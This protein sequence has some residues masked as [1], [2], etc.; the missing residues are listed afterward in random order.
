MPI[1]SVTTPGAL[2]FSTGASAAA[3]A[4]AQDAV[5]KQG[6]TQAEKEAA[7]LHDVNQGQKLDKEPVT[8]DNHGKLGKDDFM[9]LMIATL[10]YQDPSNPMDTQQ[11]L[12]QTSTMTNMEQMI[13]MTE[14]SQKAFEAQLKTQGAGMV[15]K[16][17]VYD[18]KDA[19]GD[20]VTTAGKVDA[21]EF[22][23]EGKVMVHIG[24]EKI[25]MSDILGVADPTED[26]AAAVAAATGKDGKAEAKADKAQSKPEAAADKTAEATGKETSEASGGA[27]GGASTAEVAAPTVPT[28]PAV[29]SSPVVPANASPGAAGVPRPPSAEETSLSSPSAHET[30]NNN[31]AGAPANPEA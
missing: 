1:D 29:P 4:A 17:V 7:L 27:S 9:K 13:K 10:K 6:M 23:A 14:A 21:V 5:T 18:T 24:A 30:T 16:T 2:G 25:L 26:P 3:A 31:G 15:G 20:K 8:A 19:D 12:E 28:A 22:L 11:L